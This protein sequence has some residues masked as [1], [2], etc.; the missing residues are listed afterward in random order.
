MTAEMAR[1]LMALFAAE[2]QARSGRLD[3]DPGWWMPLSLPRA[4]AE[5]LGDAQHVARMRAA[6]P[7]GLS[8]GVV[9]VGQQAPWW[10]FG[11]LLSWRQS[12]L[13]VLHS[14]SLRALLDTPEPVDGSVRIACSGAHDADNSVLV[15][16]ACEHVTARDALVMDCFGAALE[17]HGTAYGLRESAVVPPETV[18]AGDGQSGAVRAPVSSDGKACWD[19]VLPGNR[20][21]W[22][23]LSAHSSGK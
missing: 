21:S 11:S 2:L 13:D 14:P 15:E 1:R 20:A 22:A 5:R 8:L 19:V 3:T 4:L 17:V 23:E 9:D 10:D 12:C 16:V 6:F 7:E 18:V